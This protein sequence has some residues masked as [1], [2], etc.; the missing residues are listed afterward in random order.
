VPVAIQDGICGLARKS[1]GCWTM[2][3]SELAVGAVNIGD[4]ILVGRV[5]LLAAGV[6]K[7]DPAS[8]PFSE[9]AENAPRGI[10]E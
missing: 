10:G 7:V 9:T 2:R 6:L 1:R 4:A 8:T 5:A 3:A